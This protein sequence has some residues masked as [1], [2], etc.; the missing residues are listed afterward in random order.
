MFG[1]DDLLN[2]AFSWATDAIGSGL[3][4]GL[5][6]LGLS[7]HGRDQYFNRS[8]MR[9]QM[10][11]QSAEAQKNRDW[12]LQMYERQLQNYPELL[13][14]Q[15][16]SDFNKWRNQ[17]DYMSPQNMVARNLSAGVN[18]ASQGQ[19]LT[20]GVS[21]SPS[22][23][24]NIAGSP[25]G[26]PSP[27]GIPSTGMSRGLLSEIGSFM[28]DVQQAKNLEKQTGRYD[29]YLD[30]MIA[31]FDAETENKEEA[32]RY[33]K[34][35]TAIKQVYGNTEAMYNNAKLLQE[36]YSL[37]KQGDYYASNKKLVEADENLTKT[38]DSALKEQLPLLRG[39]IQS[40][41]D[42]NNAN[43]RKSRQEA[44]LASQQASY[45][46]AITKTE[47]DMRSNR[48]EAV[49]LENDL[50]TINKFLM[51][52]ELKIS[53]DTLQA[54]ISSIIEGM[55]QQQIITKQQAEK[56]YQLSVTS[57]WASRQQ[58]MQYWTGFLNSASN[59]IG[60]S[61]G[62]YNGALSRMSARERN[63]IQ[64]EFNSIIDKHYNT[65]IQPH[66]VRGFGYQPAWQE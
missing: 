26:N 32:T 46:K 1:L 52:N 58:Y 4:A 7:Q 28:R 24:P 55:K 15:A 56:L 14:M 11:W 9:E 34:I 54:Q 25:V 36:A 59:V 42:L 62:Y 64:R 33:Q 51:G 22:V 31:K 8:M 20:Q 19:A 13:K 21:S 39:E 16:D 2:S 29:E 47:N 41:I 6:S 10:E 23:P 44:Y 5:D 35:L 65:P 17:Q 61:S 18:P 50:R 66:E 27:V 57:A 3:N 37:Q 40:Q 38:K 60:S 45:Y 48:L 30:S 12:N 53:N 43:A 49:S 63:Q